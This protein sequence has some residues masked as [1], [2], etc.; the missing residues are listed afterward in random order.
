[1]ARD[2]LIVDDEE[3]IRSLL[4]GVLEDE[5]YETRSAF[6]ADS[7]IEVVRARVPNLVILDPR[8]SDRALHNHTQER[9]RPG[10]GDCQENNGRP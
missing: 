7:A 5:G 9:H 6:D 2:I 10:P 3:D 8:A 4:A 1:M